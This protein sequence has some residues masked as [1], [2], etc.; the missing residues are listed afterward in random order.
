MFHKQ[1]CSRIEHHFP[2]RARFFSHICNLLFLPL[3]HDVLFSLSSPEPGD[4][5]LVF[6]LE[7]A[8]PRY[9]FGANVDA[10][11]QATGEF[12]F[13]V[14]G[15]IGRT[16]NLKA[17]AKTATWKLLDGNEINLNLFTHR[18]LGRRDLTG[19]LVAGT[20]TTDM[21]KYSSYDEVLFRVGALVSQDQ[22][23]DGI[24]I[25]H[26]HASRSWRS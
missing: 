6:H 19:S 12:S 3:P 22:E 10:Q 25:D 20:Q 16:E 18:F 2:Q 8:R 1:V 23:V 21:K 4:V 11:G 5:D 26:V 14:P 13:D 9:T 15:F 17:T 24:I 7:K